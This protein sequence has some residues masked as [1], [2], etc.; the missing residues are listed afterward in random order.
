MVE[1]SD[2]ANQALSVHVSGLIS[3]NSSAASNPASL[4]PAS[5]PRRLATTRGFDNQGLNR[6]SNSRIA[7]ST[8]F[9]PIAGST[10][11]SSPQKNLGD[12]L[13]GI[14]ALK[15]TGTR[16][17]N[18]PSLLPRRPS[19]TPPSLPPRPSSCDFARSLLLLQLLHQK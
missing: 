14:A 4:P 2:A 1:Y 15:K 10:P 19:P 8:Y 11:L 3:N 17:A 9:A 18:T 16:Q 5:R 13:L 7:T 12:K 6:L